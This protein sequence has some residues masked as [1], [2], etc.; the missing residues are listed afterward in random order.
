MDLYITTLNDADIGF[1]LDTCKLQKHHDRYGEG[2]ECESDLLQIKDIEPKLEPGVV[3]K[4]KF[5]AGKEFE[6][7][8]AEA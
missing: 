3:Y 5:G 6:S 8:L 4:K 1:K 7:A 2:Q